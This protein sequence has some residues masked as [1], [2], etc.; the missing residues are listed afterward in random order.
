MTSTSR[1]ARRTTGRILALSVVGLSLLAA[2]C[3]SS[4]SK[5][6]E[7]SSTV[8]K[9]PEA[10]TT[11][12]A[13]N[14]ATTGAPAPTTTAKPVEPA[15]EKPVAGG[16]LKVGQESG[17][18]TLDPALALAQPADKNIA[19]SI[20]DPLMSFDKDG[21]FIPFL[22]ETVKNSDDLKTARA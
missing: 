10:T 14:T 21:K 13:G 2:A 17:V 11:T 9:A 22:A 16:D 12:A 15:G 7:S 18:S 3:G 4:S 19:L 6:A 8:A 5:T 1:P 20:Y